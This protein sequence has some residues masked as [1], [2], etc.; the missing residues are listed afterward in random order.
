M[1]EDLQTTLLQMLQRLEKASTGFRK[2]TDL[3]PPEGKRLKTSPPEEL[4]VDK[5]TVPFSEVPV[6]MINMTW[7]EKGKERITKEPEEKRLAEKPTRGVIKTPEYPKAAIIKG[8]VMCSKCQCECELEIPPTGVLIDREL[9]RRKEEDVRRE[10]REKIKQATKKDTSRSVFQRL[11]GDSQ[12][13]A[14]SEVFR[15]HEVSDEAE[16][17]E[18]RIRR[19]ADHPQCGQMGREIE[20]IDSMT[21]PGRKGNPAHLGRKWYVVRKNGQPTKPMGASMVRRVQRQH[22]AYMNSLKTPTTSEASKNQKLEKTASGGSS[23]LRWR[24]KKEVEKADSKTEGEGNHVP[25][26]QHPGKYR[27]L[28][29]AQEDLIMMPTPGW[30][31]GPN[32]AETI[33]S[34]RRP[35]SLPLV[36]HFGEVPKQTLYAGMNQQQQEGAPEPLLPADAMA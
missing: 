24:S 27:I 29:R 18:A 2:E 8:M 7:A 19:G 13:K 32:H 26:S 10:A 6:N 20:K 17:M 4:V 5:P 9:I 21:N 12:P 22:K 25:Q 28:R 33:S 34:E 15:N 35:P 36:D 3:V 14:L 30:K 23:Q 11:G 31:P 16:D 1:P